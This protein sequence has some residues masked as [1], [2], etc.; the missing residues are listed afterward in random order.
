MFSPFPIGLL[1]LVVA[2]QSPGPQKETSGEVSQSEKINPDPR[3]QLS[4]PAT[5]IFL[6]VTDPKSQIVSRVEFIRAVPNESGLTMMSVEEA[7]RAQLKLAKESGVM[8]T[9]VTAG[10]A[11]D[12]VGI[13][14]NDI[15]VLLGGHRLGK[16]EDLDQALEAVARQGIGA[17]QLG[18]IRE[19]KTMNLMVK[20]HVQVTM[21]ADEPADPKYW[22]GVHVEELDQAFRSHLNIQGNEG[23]IV[24][25]VM[26][27]SPASKAGI[28]VHDILMSLN[29]EPLTD[30]ASLVTLVQTAGEKP[31]NLVV[32]R[33]G[34]RET[35]KITP[36]V[37]SVEVTAAKKWAQTWRLNSAM[38]IYRG[39]TVS[40]AG[41][42]Q[43]SKVA[44]WSTRAFSKTDGN[45]ARLGLLVDK[46]AVPFR[47]L[48]DL[49]AEVKQ[50]RKIIEDQQK[51]LIER[52][53]KP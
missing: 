51:A 22:I 16:P 39:A 34:K 26:Y 18:M 1:V 4:Q 28:A 49:E 2:S 9:S 42:E 30:N 43:P 40:P 11:A 15:L 46:A 35:L 38:P 19:G 6:D 31:A 12:Q 27:D 45:Q 44:E 52:A 20:P 48:Q 33:A 24:N 29:D 5:E 14:T 23:L 3:S 37:R 17:A 10:S 7:L 41:A 25:V 36:A 21:G 50:L 8:V 47:Q 32:L 53:N 13:K